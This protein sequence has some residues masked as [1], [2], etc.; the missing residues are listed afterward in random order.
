MRLTDEQKAMGRGR[1]LEAVGRRDVLKAGLGLPVIAAFG[2]AVA[3]RGPLRGGPVRGALIG[4]GSQGKT[5]LGQCRNEF[6]TVKAICDIN[7]SHARQAAAALASAGRARPREYADW[8]D[9]LAKEDLEAVIVATPLWSHAE[10]AAG[11]LE[12]GKHV[13]CE[14]A[15]AHDLAGVTRMSEAARRSGRQLEIGHQRFYNPVYQAAKEN[16]IRAGALGDVFHVRLLWH[17]NGSWRRDEKAPS[18]DFDPRGWGYPDWEHLLNWRLYRKYSGGLM[19]ELGSHQTAIADWF[20]EAT[21]QAVYGTGGV[22]RYRDGR[23]VADHVYVTLEYPGGRTVTFSS[24]QSNRFDDYCEVV[25]G[26]EGTLV[27]TRESDAFLF[28]ERDERAVGLELT[29]KGGDSVA[30]ASASRLAD[31]GSG[32]TRI[33]DASTTTADALSPYG[34]EIR[35]FCSAI[36]AGTPLGCG[37]DRAA[38]AAITAILSNQAIAKQTRLG[39]PS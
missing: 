21:P 28:S 7:P 38:R 11:C 33:V 2:A 32:R 4:A 29:R 27:L 10:I 18:A 30:E 15:M 39:I 23:E 37:P 5:L 9:M 6:I 19:A 3:T 1:F 13:L 31:A 25:M 36:R 17:R 34:L 26:T 20:L 16:V 35:G 14:K 24:I 12:A 22:Y 8:R